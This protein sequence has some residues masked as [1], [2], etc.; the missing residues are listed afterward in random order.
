[1]Y[2]MRWSHTLD[3]ASDASKQLRSAF[4]AQDLPRLCA[5]LD[6]GIAV[7]TCDS[8]FGMT[9]LH[10]AAGNE[11]LDFL[12]ALL[13]RGANVNAVD[14]EQSTPMHICAL[15]GK[16]TSMVML[17][18]MGAHPLSLD[19]FG[20]TPLHVAARTPGQAAAAATLFDILSGKEDV[21]PADVPGQSS[22]ALAQEGADQSSQ[23][24]QL[25][26]R[27]QHV[28]FSR[29]ERDVDDCSIY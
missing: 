22:R 21:M 15:Q 11:R 29:S 17:A 16:L 4:I 7:D 28:Y 19:V 27:H 14:R 2:R 12:L 5:I 3:T 20:Q 18:A 10:L 8:A 6:S 9:L 26:R 24:G 25:H 1:M 23:S 13:A